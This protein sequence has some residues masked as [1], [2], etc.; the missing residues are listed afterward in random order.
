M[1]HKNSFHIKKLNHQSGYGWA[2]MMRAGYVWLAALL[3]FIWYATGR[4]EMYTAGV[5]LFIGTAFFILLY[6]VGMSVGKGFAVFITVLYFF[7]PFFILSIENIRRALLIFS[8][9]VFDYLADYGQSKNIFHRIIQNTS[10]DMQTGNVEFLPFV[11]GILGITLWLILFMALLWK[12]QPCSLFFTVAICFAFPFFVWGVRP[13][14]FAVLSFLIFCFFFFAPSFWGGVLGTSILIILLLLGTFS[15]MTNTGQMSAIQKKWNKERYKE[16]V[17]VLPEGQLTKAKK[18][19]RTDEEALKVNIYKKNS[20]YLKGFVGTTYEDN[21]YC[22]PNVDYY[23]T[24]LEQFHLRPE[25]CL[26]VGN[27]VEE[28]LAIR[29]LGV[30]TFLVTDTKENKKDLP[31]ESD[32]QGSM[33]ELFAFVESLENA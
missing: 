10:V 6:F 20:Y 7:V 1:E 32:Y 14:L 31:I 22:K 25:E 30:K 27:D 16:A 13:E 5:V 2:E 3:C 12:V 17:S 24:I 29:K 18:M 8:R 4:F 28:D 9:T 11:V 21:C 15:G 23:R 19:K 33:E 26:M